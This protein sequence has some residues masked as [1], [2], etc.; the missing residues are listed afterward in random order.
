MKKLL[1]IV[2]LILA[3]PVFSQT[4]IFEINENLGRGINMGNMFEAP[5]ETA[6]GNP[7]RDDYFLKIADLGFKH[8]RVPIRWDTPERAQQNSPYQL[9]SAFLNRIKKI[10]DDALRYN[11]RVIIN[12]H[13]HE[14]L[15]QKPEEN[16]EKFLAQWRQIADFFKNYDDRLVFEILNEPH[17]EL[18]PEKWNIFFSDALNEVR[19]TNPNRAVLLGCANFGG[20]SGVPHLKLPND[21]NLILSIH[22][23]DPFNFTHQGAEWVGNDSNQWLGTKWEDSELERAEIINQFEFAKNW[24]NEKQIPI[25]IGEFGA[26]SKA[27][28]NSRVKWTTF[29]ARWFETNNWSWAYWEFSAGFGIFNPSNGTFN[30]ELVNALLKNQMPEPLKV[31]LLPVYSSDFKTNQNNWGLFVQSPAQATL[32]RNEGK[33]Q[34]EISKNS[35]QGWHIQLVKSNITLKK[36]SSYLVTIEDN[37]VENIN[38]TAYLGKSIAPFSAY[39]GYRNFT[40]NKNSG[41]HTFTFL[42]NET[43]DENARLVF[44]LGQNLGNWNLE[45][46]NIFEIS[47]PEKL[48]STQKINKA[49]VFPNPFEDEIQLIDAEE[50]TNVSVFNAFGKKVFKNNYKI[51]KKLNLK[52]LPAGN[53]FLLLENQFA[54]QLVRITKL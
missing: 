9:N 7:Y 29:L 24:S 37:A 17:G 40:S 53:Y 12:M 45:E 25:H 1:F 15:F 3:K 42:M 26:Y 4:S 10:V 47:D 6:W 50:F 20:L 21:K 23:Y 8:V 5:N 39:S 27:D 35:N 43:T 51:D 32:K 52:H 49:M 31:N 28:L 38:F 2:I 11:L 46:V 41:I 14:L 36:G 34:I 16:K 48:L 22:F 30:Q 54:Y 18:S 19:K 44:D 33:L 13:H